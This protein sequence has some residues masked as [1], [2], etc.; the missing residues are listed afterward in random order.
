[1]F[2]EMKKKKEKKK[3]N[4]HGSYPNTKREIHDANKWVLHNIYTRHNV[5]LFLERKSQESSS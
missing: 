4:Q 1:M 5:Q 3:I 2:I